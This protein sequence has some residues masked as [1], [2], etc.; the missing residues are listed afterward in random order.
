MSVLT[1]Q[2]LDS[3]PNLGLQDL[4][5]I[6]PLCPASWSSSPLAQLVYRVLSMYQVK[7]LLQQQIG[8][9]EVSL[10]LDR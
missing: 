9:C 8:S 1:H 5:I 7:A 2:V 3:S 6:V 4:A 10:F